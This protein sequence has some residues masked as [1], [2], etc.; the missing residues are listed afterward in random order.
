MFPFKPD[1]TIVVRLRPKSGVAEE[2]TSGLLSGEYERNGSAIRASKTKRYVSFLEEVPGIPDPT[3]TLEA[4]LPM[5]RLA[6]AAS[7]VNL[8][9]SAV[10]FAVVVQRL[11]AIEKQL[12][13]ISQQLKRL[14]WKADLGFYA[15]V[16]AAL[17]LAKNAYAMKRG[18]N[19]DKG[20]MQAID[21]LFEAEQHF[22]PLLARDLEEGARRSLAFLNTILLTHSS[23]ARCYAEVEELEIARKHL[24]DHVAELKPLVQGYRDAVIGRSLPL[25]LHP[26]LKD[27]V[28]LVRI[29]WLLGQE[30]EG[31]TPAE[32]FEEMRKDLWDTAGEDPRAWVKRM[33]DWMTDLEPADDA[34]QKLIRLFDRSETEGRR[35]DTRIPEVIEDIGGDAKKRIIDLLHG[36]YAEWE[37]AKTRM[38]EVLEHAEEAYEGLNRLRGFGLELDY[39]AEH[40]MSFADWQAV[41][42]PAGDKEAIYAIVPPDSP[43]YDRAETAKKRLGAEA[44]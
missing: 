13:V 25:Y 9:I 39:L 16:Y 2:I 17:D 42:P 27:T 38:P 44:Q 31:I 35:S 10:G 11:S 14:D 29:A 8:G 37:I 23:I 19:R 21:R 5:T 30:I 26:D 4:L 1:G 7:V 36:G 28:S 18:D 33:P 40:G 43:L 32:A 12:K 41:A 15:N 6:A 20:L 34:R 22:T 3:R 24:R